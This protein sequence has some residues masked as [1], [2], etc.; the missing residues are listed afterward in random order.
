MDRVNKAE[1][2]PDHVTLL[3]S[4]LSNKPCHLDVG[5]GDV[6]PAGSNIRF[7]KKGR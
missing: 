6:A 2:E 7:L 4:S 5:A 3:A 1:S